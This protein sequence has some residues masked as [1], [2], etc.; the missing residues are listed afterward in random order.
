MLLLLNRVLHCIIV[1]CNVYL[2]AS[3]E[4]VIFA[5]LQSLH[6]DYI[7]SSLRFSPEWSSVDIFIQRNGKCPSSSCLA[8][9]L[10]LGVTSH[11]M[12]KLVQF[13]IDMYIGVIGMPL[14]N[15]IK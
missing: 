4:S 6:V 12:S 3:M 1:D 9:L 15:F 8:I 11:W 10:N 7:D 13:D 5:D 14:I 2:I